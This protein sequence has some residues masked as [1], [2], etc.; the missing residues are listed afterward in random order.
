[1]TLI[2][3]RT[4]ATLSRLL[5]NVDIYLLLHNHSVLAHSSPWTCMWRYLNINTLLCVRVLAGELCWS[6]SPPLNGSFHNIRTCH[7]CEWFCCNGR[8]CCQQPASHLD[9]LIHI[10]FRRQWSLVVISVPGDPR[11]LGGELWRRRNTARQG[12]ISVEKTRA[13]MAHCQRW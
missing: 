3:Y 2:L 7:A 10:S 12:F 9:Q 4:Q 1:L 5:P 8:R 6:T 11:K 13:G